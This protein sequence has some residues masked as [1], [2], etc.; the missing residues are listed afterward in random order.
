MIYNCAGAKWKGKW[1]VI[2]CI[3]FPRSKL[4]SII[5]IYCYSIF[6]FICM[7][8]RSLFVLLYFW[9]WPLSWFLLRFTDSDFP[10][11][12]FKLFYRSSCLSKNIID[13][14]AYTYYNNSYNDHYYFVIR[15][16]YRGRHFLKYFLELLKVHT[17]VHLSIMKLRQSWDEWRK[18]QCLFNTKNN[19]L[20]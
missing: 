1:D 2:L 4:N 8:C 13:N 14:C 9:F 3:I 17:N 10:F 5:S 16:Y 7:F 20:D 12:I 19:P 15:E 6:S 18:Y 11:G